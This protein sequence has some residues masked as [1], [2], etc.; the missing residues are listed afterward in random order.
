MSEQT[1][2]VPVGVKL[3][4][5]GD[6]TFSIPDG[7]NGVGVT[8]IDSYNGTHTN[9]SALDYTVSLEAGTYDDRFLL[10]I[11]PIH[12]TPTEIDGVESQKSKVES[13]TVSGL[14]SSSRYVVVGLRRT[15]STPVR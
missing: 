6:Y 8:L 15:V 1:T 12:S 9:L 10:Q 4:A 3:A 11:S 5:D 7:T 2:I 14:A 13:R